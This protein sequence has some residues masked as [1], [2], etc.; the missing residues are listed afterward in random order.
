MTVPVELLPPVTVVGFRL[1]LVKLTAVIVNPALSVVV[2]KL[3]EIV[4]TVC[5]ATDLV[6]IGNVALVAPDA[7]VTFAGTVAAA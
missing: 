5:A 4:A 3:A 2:P 1:T 6:V 7:M